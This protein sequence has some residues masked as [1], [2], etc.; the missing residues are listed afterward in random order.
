M[1]GYREKKGNFEMTNKL[2]KYRQKRK[3]EV[4]PEP[5]GDVPKKKT[6]ELIFVIHHHFARREHW[7]FRLEMDSVLKSWAVPK[8]PPKQVGI[9]RLAIQVKDHPLEYASFHGQIPQGIY[10]AGTVKIWDKGTYA[11][12]EK[13]KNKIVFELKGKK[14]KGEY[15]LILFRPPKNWLFFKNKK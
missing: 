12:L 3:F 5:K 15:S 1:D 7:D 11:L 2:K 13:T 14:L 10:G 6:K 9:K 4:T 8:E